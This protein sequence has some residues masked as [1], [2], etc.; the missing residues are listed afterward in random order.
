MDPDRVVFAPIENIQ[1]S[2][3]TFFGDELTYKL[4]FEPV[5][6]AYLKKKKVAD[7][8]GMEIDQQTFFKVMHEM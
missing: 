3:Q 2:F 6:I 5:K 7:T 1:K 8:P 4:T